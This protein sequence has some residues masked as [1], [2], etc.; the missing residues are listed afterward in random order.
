MDWQENVFLSLGRWFEQHGKAIYGTCG[1]SDYPFNQELAPWQTTRRG[2]RMYLILNRYPGQHLSI[3]NLHAHRI[4]EAKLLGSDWCLKVVREST[5]CLIQGLPAKPPDP[6]AGVVELRI[7]PTEAP[8]D[9]NPR[10]AEH[11]HEL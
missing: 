10:W 2:E 8:H 11:T 9:P 1:V 7:E 6:L 3:A 4:R 5:R